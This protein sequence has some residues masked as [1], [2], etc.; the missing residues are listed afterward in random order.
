[1][2]CCH[3]W[4]QLALV[5]MKRT[6]IAGLRGMHFI[7]TSIFL[8]LSLSLSSLRNRSDLQLFAILQSLFPNKPIRDIR[9]RLLRLNLVTK[10]ELMR[11]K[12]GKKGKKAK[13]KRERDEEEEEGEGEMEMDAEAG[14]EETEEAS[15]R[16]RQENTPMK[17]TKIIRISKVSSQHT[18]LQMIM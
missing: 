9:K 12:K 1:M 10:Q 18:A 11:L 17:S 14:A 4:R 8:S 2:T 13:K 3:C 16:Q 7:P 15:S 5:T 6:A